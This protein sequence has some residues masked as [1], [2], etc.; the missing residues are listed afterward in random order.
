MRANNQIRFHYACTD[1]GGGGINAWASSNNT[2][3]YN[4]WQHV[5]VAY[6]NSSV[7]NQPTIYINGS[8]VS[9]TQIFF[10]DDDPCESDAINSLAVG[11]DSVE[12]FTFDGLID[13]VRVYNRAL[14]TQEIKRLY[15]MG[16]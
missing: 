14:S 12:V 15:Q 3:S 2:I 7:A 10:A 5:V 9:L 11:N 13:D 4:A 16:R 1:L 6:N 8:S